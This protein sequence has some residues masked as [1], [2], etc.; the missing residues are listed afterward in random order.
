MELEEKLIEQ[1]KKEG[2]GILFESSPKFVHSIPKLEEELNNFGFN[3][4]AFIEFDVGDNPQQFLEER[5][6]GRV[7]SD[8]GNVYH[9][10]FNPPPSSLSSSSLSTR[11]DDKIENVVERVKSYQNN[12]CKNFFLLFLFF[13]L[14]FKNFVDLIRKY[15]K[16]IGKYHSVDAQ[17]PI[18]QVSC[19]IEKI[20]ENSKN[21][22]N[23]KPLKSKYFNTTESGSEEIEKIF[24]KV[25]FENSF[26]LKKNI[27]E[28]L[29]MN[30]KDL[31][32]FPTKSPILVDP[33][34]VFNSSFHDYTFFLQ[35]DGFRFFCCF[36]DSQIFIVN[37]KMRIFKLK[38]FVNL[39]EPTKSTFKSLGTTILDG[40][41]IFF[42]FFFHFLFY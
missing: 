42:N 29:E 38:S 7:E 9:S 26:S 12:I 11:S 6:N 37:P 24:E 34:T 27:F 2:R 28:H 22:E 23:K 8:D 41:K 21:S 19:E 35:A 20:I 1:A 15:F 17:K 33:D 32:Y 4:R 31:R 13:L 39:S 18:N 3:I 40:K 5:A 25:D 10:S 30:E 36:Y 14:K 16:G